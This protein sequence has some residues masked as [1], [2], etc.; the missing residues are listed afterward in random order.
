MAAEHGWL[1]AHLWVLFWPSTCERGA[2]VRG[3]LRSDMC[4]YPATR[5][6]HA[7]VPSVYKSTRYFD[8]GL[9]RP[10]LHVVSGLIRAA[11]VCT[12]AAACISTTRDRA[13]LPATAWW[14]V[15][16]EDSVPGSSGRSPPQNLA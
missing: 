9:H 4:R 14:S 16:R 13:L 2:R 6:G 3:S 5:Y 15:D 11:S 1:M 10:C 8:I 7:Q 12:P